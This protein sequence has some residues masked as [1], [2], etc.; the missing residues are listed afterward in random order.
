MN[1]SRRSSFVLGVAIITSPVGLFAQA[2]Q[3]LT[4][5]WHDNYNFVYN[6]TQS[7]NSVS[8]TVQFP[9]GPDPCPGSTYSV[10]GS[11]SQSGFT[12]TATGSTCPASSYTYTGANY[13]PGCDHGDGSWT[14]NLGEAGNFSW[15]NSDACPLP[16]YE[17]T[18]DYGWEF[19][20]GAV[21]DW[22]ATVGSYSG[23]L[24]GGRTVQEVDGGGGSDNCWISQSPYGKLDHI[25][26]PAT[27]TVDWNESYID[28]V[29]WFNDPFFWYQENRQMYGY[30]LPCGFQIPNQ[31]MQMACAA[32][33]FATY[34]NNFLGGDVGI[35]TATS[36]RSYYSQSHLWH[37]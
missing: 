27:W 4:G 10:S 7:G 34:N 24:F 3:G 8:G 17:N 21:Y 37:R 32:G 5:T 12:F 18:G 6:L 28:Q 25:P 16:D 14:N 22:K 30:P 31:T 29:G 19:I 1:R 20:Q 15:Y 13:P 36:Y 23:Q 11:V 26:N 35:E 2:C 9:G 33:S